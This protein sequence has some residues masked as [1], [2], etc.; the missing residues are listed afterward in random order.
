MNLANIVQA[1]KSRCASFS[2]RVAGAAEF[3]LLP[4][5]AALPVPAAYVVPLDESTEPVQGNNNR[6]TIRESFAVIVALKPEDARGQGAT[7]SLHALRAELFLALLGWCPDTDYTEIEYEGG[8]LLQMDRGRMWFQFEFASEWSIDSSD[9]YQGAAQDALPPFEG[10]NLEV[11]FIDPF[12]PNRADIGPDGTIDAG[13]TI[14][15]PQS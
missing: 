7:Q 4:E 12:D 2:N 11:D 10:I 8:Q 15:L 9:T 13:M 5:S 6:Q 3:K 1:V 14:D